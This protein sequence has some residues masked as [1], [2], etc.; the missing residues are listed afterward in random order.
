MTKG[1]SIIICCYNSAE[2]IAPT[3]KHIAQQH[4][5]A[6][7]LWEVIV[8]NNNSTDDT[9]SI[10]W[11]YWEEYQ[12][13]TTM[14]VV[15]EPQ[16]GLSFAREA[17]INAAKYEYIIFCDDDNWLNN[18]YL[19]T[20]FEI[21]N[22]HEDVGIIGGWGEAVCE[23][24][25]PTWFLNLHGQ[26][27]ACSKQ[28]VQSGKV[29]HRNGVVYGAGMGMRKSVF[30]RLQQAGFQFSL[31]DRQGKS[32][33]TGGDIELGLAARIAG[34]EIWYDERLRFKHF[35]TASR[36]TW[37]YFVRLRNH[38]G[39]AMRNIIPYHHHLQNYPSSRLFYIC[40]LLKNIAVNLP[41]YII[42]YPFSSFAERQ[43]SLHFIYSLRSFL[44]AQKFYLE[45]RQSIHQFAENLSRYDIQ[46]EYS[47]H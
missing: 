45:Q 43:F 19:Q 39:L 26:Y 46:H 17:G 9:S 37:P 24:E 28:Y 5:P 40:W 21:F 2:R 12:S 13:P 31:T 8:V 3:L 15:F 18:N 34:Y 1:V 36:L 33:V 7:I 32:T 44:H 16:Q 27:Y 41:L 38:F 29:L 10:A 11:S 4:V 6:S 35:I 30:I 22:E 25:P 47:H 14:T 42:K 20:V 23:K